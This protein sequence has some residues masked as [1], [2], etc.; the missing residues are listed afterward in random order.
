GVVALTKAGMVEEEWLEIVMDDV[1]GHLKDTF[2]ADAPILAV[3]SL[4]G[5]GIPELKKALFESVA[6]AEARNSALPF[7]LPVDRVFTRPGFGTVITGT[8]VAGT[9]RVGD[10]VEALPQRLLTRVRGLQSHGKTQEF[11][12]AGSRVA[13]NLAGVETASLERGAVLAPP[14]VMAP[15]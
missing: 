12:E 7:R 5:R 13:V 1:R 2:L 11:V 9:L 8:L 3:D 10:G 6:R 15:T 4:S 14:G